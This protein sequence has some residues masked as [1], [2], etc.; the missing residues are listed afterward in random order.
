[1][2]RSGFR[3]E[4]ELVRGLANGDRAGLVDLGEKLCGVARGRFE[5]LVGGQPASTS[6]SSSRCR[7][8]PGVRPK[9]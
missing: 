2:S 9:R 1:M 7:P 5:R 8:K 4:Q 3:V 6:A